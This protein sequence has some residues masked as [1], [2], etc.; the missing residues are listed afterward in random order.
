MVNDMDG[1]I[2]ISTFKDDKYGL[3]SCFVKDDKVVF[4]YT[5]VF[6]NKYTYMLVSESINNELVVRYLKEYE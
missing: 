5:R 2:K 6:N 4:A 1:F 3:I